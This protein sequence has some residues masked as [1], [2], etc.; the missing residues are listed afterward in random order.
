MLTLL[1]LT[2][3]EWFKLRK[4]W[5]PWILVFVAVAI[6]Q[7]FLWSMFYSY[8]DR[9]SIE[10][11][12]TFY[13][14][15][16]TDSAGNSTAIPVSC[17][18]IWE[19]TADAKVEQS[20]E[21]LREDSLRTVEF[22]QEKV[23]QDQMEEEARFHDETRRAFVLPDSVSNGLGVAQSI[24]AVLIMVLAS[25]VVGTEYGW[26]TLRAALTRGIGRWQLLGAKL[27][28]LV[29][30]SAAGF[31]VVALTI[32]VSSFIA[33]SAVQN[34]G[35]L[36]DAGEWSTVAVMFG[37]AVYGLAPY[38]LLALFLSVLTSS[39]SVSIA[40]SLAYFFAESILVQILDGLFDWF[41]NVTDYLLGPSVTSWMT[42]AGVRTTGEGAM[43]PV[44]DPSS[45]WHAFFVIAAYIII[46][47]VAAFWLFQRR[48][49]A[50]AR[51]E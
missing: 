20:D 21:T 9:L 40:F 25:S 2:R 42:E 22:L 27:L 3:W 47:G 44:S 4:R 17:I 26:G 50:G 33:A 34:G 24:G 35:G 28:S 41:G 5:M 46:L 13:L 49:V 43:F 45:Q 1:N 48:D 51:G 11:Q 23:C 8:N 19:G 30:L 6:A 37:K 18:D 12:T 16:P 31:I 38:A 10:E 39:S 7:A 32:G 15:G 14:T 29:V 36:A